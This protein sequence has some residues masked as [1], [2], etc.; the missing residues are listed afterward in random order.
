MRILIA[1]GGQAAALVA[2]R[3]IREG[4]E[5]VIVEQKPERGLEMEV[6]VDA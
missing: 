4:N 5:V 2:A 3:L 1:G 6:I